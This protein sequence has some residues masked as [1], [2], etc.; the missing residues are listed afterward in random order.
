[1]TEQ[2]LNPHC[3][4]DDEHQTPIPKEYDIFIKV[5][6][7]D[8]EGN[9]T[10][11]SDQTGRFP[12]KSSRGNQYIM[13]LAHP[14]SNG[15]LQEPMKNRTS[16]KMICAYQKLIDRLKSAGIT[17]KCHILDNECSTDFKQTI[18]D[19]NMTYQLVPPHDHRRNMAEKAIQTFK[20]HFISIL[21][22][23]D[24]DFPLHLWD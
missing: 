24:K 14:D 12:K 2:P 7:I 6:A 5:I 22:G 16:G 10:C 11:H 8:K 19:N 4:N 23:A 1:M 18:R 13:V 9:A 3:K 17:P 21:C 20:A 15:I